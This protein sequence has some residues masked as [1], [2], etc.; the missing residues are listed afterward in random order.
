MKRVHLLIGF[1]LVG[2]CTFSQNVHVGI[3]TGLSAYNGDLTDK[4]FPKKV[5]NGAIGVTVNYELTPQIMLRGGLLIPLSV[6]L[7]VS[8]IMIH[9]VHE[10]WL[11]KLI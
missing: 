5:T 9:C 2:F 11:L 1:L 8:V 4:I 10:T 7:I 6:V 3:F